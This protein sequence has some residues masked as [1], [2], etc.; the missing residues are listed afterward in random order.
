MHAERVLDA[1]GGDRGADDV[2][3]RPVRDFARGR[4]R[5]IHAL[6]R[7][8]L[9][10]AHEGAHANSRR[11]ARSNLVVSGGCL[12]RIPLS[13]S[14]GWSSL[15]ATSRRSPAST[16]MWPQGRS[17]ACSAPTAPARPRSSACSRRCSEPDAGTARGARARRR[18]GRRELREQI[19]LA[20]QYAAVDEN[21]TGLENLVMVGRLYGM[22]R[23]DG[24]RARAKSCSSVRPR[25][26]GRAAGRRPTRAGMRRRLD[27][28]GGARRQAAGAVPRR[29]DD[30]PRPAQ[31]ARHVGRDRGARRRRAR[32]CC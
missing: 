11:R 14:V 29:A 26:R 17:S 22:S 28:G 16:S 6:L 31:P 24:D 4:L 13:A 15:S 2:G 23:R 3:D 8:H 19:G 30:R 32:P 9:N 7:G 1:L 5:P 21:L 25:G 18:A 27:L 10:L 20:G 12:V